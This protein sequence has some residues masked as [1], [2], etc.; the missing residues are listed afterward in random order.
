MGHPLGTRVSFPWRQAQPSL[1]ALGTDT[2]A[3]WDGFHPPCQV[4]SSLLLL[5]LELTYFITY[6]HP[7]PHRTF[8]T[9]VSSAFPIC[10][11]ISLCEQEY[12]NDT[13]V[14]VYLL[15]VYWRT[16][17]QRDYR[18]FSRI[19]IVRAVARPKDSRKLSSIP[20]SAPDLPLGTRL[21]ISS[22]TV[23]ACEFSPLFL[24]GVKQLIS[25]HLALCVR[26]FYRDCHL[27]R[28]LRGKITLMFPLVTKVTV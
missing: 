8:I 20:S 24:S 11:L 27:G 23:G 9:C 1:W 15:L 26:A 12:P 21:S 2:S 18:A 5:W 4:C 13:H 19:K 25:H 28:S 14:A 7:L 22:L 6:D 3:S 10:C 16:P 17:L